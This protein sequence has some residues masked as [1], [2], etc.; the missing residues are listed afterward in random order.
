MSGWLELILATVEDLCT[1]AHR[2]LGEAGAV[3]RRIWHLK[4]SA[5]DLFVLDKPFLNSTI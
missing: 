1:K 2:I 3:N 5:R 4:L